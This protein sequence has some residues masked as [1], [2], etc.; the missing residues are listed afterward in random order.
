MDVS[1]EWRSGERSAAWN[2]FWAAV[3]AGPLL[4]MTDLATS[5]PDHPCA[6]K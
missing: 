3:F 6:S 2:A 1:V 4:E 5:P